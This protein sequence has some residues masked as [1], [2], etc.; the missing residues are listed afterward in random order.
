MG[1][2]KEVLDLLHAMPIIGPWRRG[3]A[4]R[5]NLDDHVFCQAVK[6]VERVA[7]MRR[8]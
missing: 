7:N 4:V 8:R 2:P 3:N 6:R 1:Q 5:E